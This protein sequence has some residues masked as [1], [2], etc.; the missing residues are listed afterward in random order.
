MLRL[1]GVGRYSASATAT[2]AFGKEHP[3]VDGTSARVYRRVFGLTASKESEVDDDL[4]ELVAD[5]TPRKGVIREWNWVVLDLASM[6]CLPKVPR[7]PQCPILDQCTFGSSRI[8][9]M[10]QGSSRIT[11]V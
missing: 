1:S 7:C 3:T 10:S 2:S 4:W 11:S 8:W 6:I 5:V 9:T